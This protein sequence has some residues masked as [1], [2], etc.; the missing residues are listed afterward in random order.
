MIRTVST[1]AAII[2]K[3]KLKPQEE[4]FTTVMGEEDESGGPELCPLTG[5][6]LGQSEDKPTSADDNSMPEVDEDG[7]M[8]VAMSP[9][10]SYHQVAPPPSRKNEKPKQPAR[11]LLTQRR[12]IEAQQQEE[13]EQQQQEQPVAEQEMISIEGEDGVIYQITPEQQQ[14]LIQNGTITMDSCQ[15]DVNY[16]ISFIQM[17]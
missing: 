8:H 11:S 14:M 15:D 10:G 3:D 4:E 17:F 1:P 16:L 2:R 13:A 5:E 9:G 12:N 7:M 6:I